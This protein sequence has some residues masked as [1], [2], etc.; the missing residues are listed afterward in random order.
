MIKSIKA[1]IDLIIKINA[2]M[3]EKINEY[4]DE[5]I[6]NNTDINLER[7]NGIVKYFAKLK[8]DIANQFLSAN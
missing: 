2:E 6:S 5:C 7:L 4:I 8:N 1:G 3:V